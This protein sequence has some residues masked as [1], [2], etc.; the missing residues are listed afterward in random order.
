MALIKCPEC[1]Q[2]ISTDCAVC[3][4]CGADIKKARGRQQTSGKAALWVVLV[5]ILICFAIAFSTK[6]KGMTASKEEEK[7]SIIEDVNQYSQISTE[8]LINKFG[9][10][11]SKENWTNKTS[12]GNFEVETYSYDKDSNHYEFITTNNLIVRLTIYSAQNWT[13]EGDLF[14]YKNKKQIPNA[15]G[16]SLSEGAKVEVDNNSTYK[17]SHVSD[18]IAVLDIQDMKPINGTFGFVK[19][20]YNAD[21]FD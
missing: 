3:P 21:Y 14:T 20:T 19:V 13:G 5:F 17:I 7:I 8:E 9:E 4:K 1:K 18:S 15:F 2:K 16:V 6:G 12:K 10:P 11:A